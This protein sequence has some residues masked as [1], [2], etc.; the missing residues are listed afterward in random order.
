MVEMGTVMSAVQQALSIL[1]KNHEYIV[2][3]P[4]LKGRLEKHATTLT[5]SAPEL[6][7]RRWNEMMTMLDLHL[8]EE[9][10]TTDW[11]RELENT[12]NALFH[13]NANTATDP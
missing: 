6:A 13:E 2:T 9:N 10:A 8:T 1:A 12:L 7:N 11:F 3:Y 4:V 5:Y